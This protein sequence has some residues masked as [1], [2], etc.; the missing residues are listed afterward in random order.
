MRL[1]TLLLISLLLASAP[2]HANQV[3][4]GQRG[5]MLPLSKIV[6]LYSKDGETLDDFALRMGIW[7]RNFTT[8]SGYEACGPV[9]V[10]GTGNGWAVP[11]VTNLSQ[12]GC[13]MGDHS[14]EGFA[15]TGVTIHSHPVERLVAPNAQ[16]R[17]FMRGQSARF[18]AKRLSRLKT[19]PGV[20][21]STD[22]ASGPGYLVAN[23]QVMFQA[24]RKA[25]RVV[26]TLPP[27]SEP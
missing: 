4:F 12:Q 8:T 16:D 13:V 17:T 19:D 25:V 5:E 9:L 21:S 27:M 11:V 3:R 22:F 24:G 23:G 2:A 1:L 26:G 10:N 20:F 7:F 14:V 6:T 18:E 15:N